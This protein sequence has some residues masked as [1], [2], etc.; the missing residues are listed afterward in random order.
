MEQIHVLAVLGGTP[1]PRC[2]PLPP[3]RPSGDSNS[4]PFPIIRLFGE[5]L[6]YF[7]WVPGG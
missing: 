4:L 1:G 6:L 7:S 5:K 3:P 2:D